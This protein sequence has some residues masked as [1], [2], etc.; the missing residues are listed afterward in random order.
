MTMAVYGGV[1]LLVVIITVVAIVL[2][3]SGGPHRGPRM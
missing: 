3:E 2:I 1:A